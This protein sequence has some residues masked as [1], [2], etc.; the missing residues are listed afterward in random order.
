MKNKS[1]RRAC[2]AAIGI[3]AGFS[4]LPRAA[5]QCAPVALSASASAAAQGRESLPLPPDRLEAVMTFFAVD[6]SIPLDAHVVE[7]RRV[8]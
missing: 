5:A 2:F 3:L 1:T 4:H 8:L 7:R 6:H